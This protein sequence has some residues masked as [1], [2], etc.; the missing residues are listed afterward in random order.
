MSL[1]A[2]I[3]QEHA[4]ATLRAAVKAGRVHHAWVFAGPP[5]V[6]KFT[7]ARAFGAE[8]LLPRTAD[9]GRVAA[10]LA[11]GSHPDL[12][13]VAKE[14]G[15][16]SR[17]DAVRR[18]KQL[19]IAQE[20]VREFLLEPASR[21]RA[22]EA[23]SIAHKVFVVDGAE[24]LDRGGQDCLLKTLEEPPPGTVIILV[25]SS[26]HELSP[27]IRSR[28]QR[29]AFA[30]LD[31][32]SFGR[33]LEGSGLVSGLPKDDGAFVRHFAA[34]SPGVALAAVRTGLVEWWRSIGPALEQVDAGRFPLAFG[35]E[36]ASLADAWAKARVA[37][38]P[39]A[40]KEAANRAAARWMFRLIGEHYRSS[41]RDAVGSGRDAAG[42]AAAIDILARAELH[43]DRSV[44]L[45]FVMDN[46]GAQLSV[47]GLRPAG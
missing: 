20:V 19:N 45:P 9:E 4:V 15:A 46:L 18:Q 36:L 40:S 16:V 29:V 42:A 7:A 38:N 22:V 35:Q 23:D 5:G 39:R 1:D 47:G 17:D 6:G 31:E 28:S 43:A 41:L 2:I 27:T 13:V 33:W 34:G 14:L 26:E 37:E 3:G 44:Q 12:H 30:P 8:L 24:E 10:L 25:T 11:S 32:R 21:T